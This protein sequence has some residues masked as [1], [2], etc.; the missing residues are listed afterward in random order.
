M[1][2]TPWVDV[3]CTVAVGQKEKPHAAGPLWL[4]VFGFLKV[5]GIFD[6]WPMAL[7]RIGLQM[8]S[9]KI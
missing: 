7:L 9:R 4:W 3:F 6:P 2:A 5:P 8:P 1:K